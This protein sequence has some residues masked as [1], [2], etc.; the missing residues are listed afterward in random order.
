MASTTS[1]VPFTVPTY[2]PSQ[3]NGGDVF[4]TNVNTQ[5]TGLEFHYI[6]LVICGYLVFLIVPGIGLFYAGLS[7]RKSGLTMLFLSFT[8]LAVVT[9]QWI[10]WG[11]S[12]AFSR[13]AHPF[14]GTLQNFVMR[15]TIAAPAASSAVIPDIVYCFY[16]LMFCA[17]TVMIVV[18]GAVDRG[19][20][21]PA[22]V[23]GFLWATIVYCPIACWTWN[24]NGWLAKLPALDFAGGGP[25]HQSSGWAALAYA[26]VVGKRAGTPAGTRTKPHN[27]T[28]VFLGTCLI[29]F[30][31]FGFNGGSAL[32]GSVRAMWAAFNTNVAACFGAIGWVTV[33][34]IRHRGRFSLIGAC[35]GVVA[36]LVGITPAAGYV[37]IWPAAAIGFFTAVVCAVAG[38]VAPAL[39]VDDGLEV[40]KLHAIGGMMGS[41]LTGIFADQAISALDG[42]SMYPGGVN[43]NG[44]QIGYQLIEILAI[45]GWSFTVS[46]ILLFVLDK[47]PG[48]KLRVDEEAEKSG[49]DGQMFFD[50]RIGEWDFEGLGLFGL[51]TSKPSRDADEPGNMLSAS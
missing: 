33:D 50:E 51:T 6:Y 14:I 17:C 44:K 5:Y 13:D 20:I 27:A 38:S 45:A 40:F 46:A 3:P 47:V 15:H 2:D 19:R 8:V 43:G 29:W 28:L 4:T 35:E 31:W 39:R 48:M 11:Y 22:L 9:F 26:A 1:E 21:L 42:A 18:G 10:F 34:L 12:L 49:I 16:Q 32:N 37:S 25:V 30:G 41:F 23:F 24:V 36:G 7:R